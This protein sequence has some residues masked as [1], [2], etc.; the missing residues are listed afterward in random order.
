MGDSQ[1]LSSYTTQ[2]RPHLIP[3]DAKKEEGAKKADTTFNNPEGAMVLLKKE[4]REEEF[5]FAATKKKS[6]KG[7]KS[8][9]DTKKTI[10]HDAATF[11]LFDQLKLDAPLSTDEIPAIIAKLEEQLKDYDEKVLS[12]SVTVKR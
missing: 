7:K 9:E 2:K 1:S 3:K 12:G 11:K 6:A 5:Y 4:D 8:K 10:K